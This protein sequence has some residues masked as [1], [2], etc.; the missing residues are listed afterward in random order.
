MDLKTLESLPPWNWPQ[1]AAD[2]I[3]KVLR[4]DTASEADRLIAAELGGDYVVV[5]D[6]L[7]EALMAI[8]RS[9]EES[10]QLRARAAIS[11]GPV[12]ETA[13]IEEF[14]DPDEVPITEATF[15]KIQKTLHGVFMDTSTPKEVRRRVLEGAIRA[16]LEWHTPA[17]RAAYASDDEEWKLTA[18]FAMQHVRGFD[19]EIVEALTH[20]NPEIQYEAIRAAGNWE[21]DA[22]WDHVAGLVKAR[23]TKQALLLAAIEAVGN[24]R[25][26]EAGM[27]LVDLTDSDDEDIVEAA[28][29]AMSM[30]EERSKH[31]FDD[32]EDGE[33]YI[34]PIQ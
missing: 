19:R 1:D 5:N 25:P 29:E 26:T 15:L 32:D 4:D 34:G 9:N 10:E 13:D 2:T 3:L 8:V 28:H 16:P 31:E 18:V 27:V 17:I 33:D 6:Q 12:L 24:I 22:A 7:A 14:D 20:P 30:A 11:F 23:G 21:V